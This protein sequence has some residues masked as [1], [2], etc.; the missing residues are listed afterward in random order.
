[1]ENIKQFIDSIATQD[2]RT[3][4]S[5]FNTLLQDRVRDVLEIKRV[6]LS[7]KIYQL[8]DSEK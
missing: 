4:D 2:T 8:P 5:L 6:E 7:G 3:A 1:M